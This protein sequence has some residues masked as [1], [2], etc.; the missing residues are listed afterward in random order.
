MGTSPDSTIFSHITIPTAG[1]RL[2]RHTIMI[3]AVDFDNTI[4]YTE[5]LEIKEEVPYAC[6][7][8][9]QLQADGHTL[10]LWTCRV[11]KS[12]QEAVDWC[13]ANNIYFHAVNQG[14]ST[15]W[16]TS[17][18]IYADIYIDDRG[19]P[20]HAVNLNWREIYDYIYET[21]ISVRDPV[22]HLP[23]YSA[24]TVI[25]LEY[26]EPLSNN[27]EFE[28]L[29][30]AH[31]Y[32]RRPRRF[33]KRYPA[34]SDAVRSVGYNPKKQIMEVQFRNGGVYQYFDIEEDTYEEFVLSAPSMG[35]FMHDR[36]IGYYDYQRIR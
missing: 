16:N 21:D 8:L 2:A 15:E 13:A 28:M 12:L 33:M 19:Y 25:D 4:A 3:I 18:K 14:G 36:I 32:S 17:R 11:D 29:P 27:K 1:A 7:S 20:N 10:I 24:D 5:N 23:Y 22:Q 34:S 9:A 31:S 35:R 30:L 26:D 6:E